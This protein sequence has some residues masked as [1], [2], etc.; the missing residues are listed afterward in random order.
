MH[1]Y[2]EYFKNNK[3]F[4]RLMEGLLKKYKSLG[5][6]SGIIKINNLTSEEANALSRFL[7]VSLVSGEDISIKV[8]QF[9]KIM[10]NSKYYDFDINV[11]VK[12]YFNIELISNKDDKS[13]KESEELKFYDE[14]TLDN[15]LGSRWLRDT[16]SSKNET[17]KLIHKRYLQNKINL[18]K[19]IVYVQSLINNLP[20]KKVLLSIYSAKY[21][22][23]P[24]YIDLDSVHSI[25]FFHALSY[26]SKCTYPFTRESKIRLLDKYNIEIDNFSNFV[27]TYNLLTDKD[28]INSFSKNNESL[29][30]NM[31]NIMNINSLNGINRKVFIFENPSIL[32]EIME[33][34]LNISVIITSGFINLSVYLLLD[35]LV[36]NGNK[37]YYNGDFDPEGLLIASK[38][39]EKY[40]KNIEFICYTKDDYY[41]CLS[42]NIATKK[43]LNKLQSVNIDELE[44]IKELLICN[45]RVAYQE[46]NKERIISVIN[47]I[48][49]GTV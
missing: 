11:L 28:Y 38:L 17:Y 5:T 4:V 43:R 2:T 46:N 7:G 42:Q 22:Q 25:L 41:N 3:G 26:I 45:N 37:L 49:K 13:K 8:K 15:S 23:D 36:E 31:Q 48:Y 16:V 1:S 19:E 34:G 6:F 47:D 39:K 14:L 24:H 9:L 12:E 20:S 10:S 29:I 33:N 44:I 30:L 18:K 32:S 27:I 21:T 40:G 35:K